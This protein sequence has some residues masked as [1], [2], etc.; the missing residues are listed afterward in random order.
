MCH[1]PPHEPARDTRPTPG[2][3]RKLPASAPASPLA[4]SVWPQDPPRRDP[5]DLGNP[6]LGPNPALPTRVGEASS[7][8][9]FLKVPEFPLKSHL[10]ST[11]WKHLP[12]LQQ[13]PVGRAMGPASHPRQP[14]GDTAQEGPSPEGRH[15]RWARGSRAPRGSLPAGRGGPHALRGSLSNGTPTERKWVP[16]PSGGPGTERGVGHVAAEW[17]GRAGALWPAIWVTATNAG[18]AA[19]GAM[20]PATLWGAPRAPPSAQSG[21]RASTLPGA[22]WGRLPI[23]EANSSAGQTSPLSSTNT[24]HS[25]NQEKDSVPSRRRQ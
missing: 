21:R 1:G 16:A 13:G 23:P 6:G 24:G 18:P 7:S 14:A 11:A 20:P 8:C 3:Q 9:G 12:L 10:S 19:T 17:R 15:P 22:E 5:R 4:A 2:R 25:Q